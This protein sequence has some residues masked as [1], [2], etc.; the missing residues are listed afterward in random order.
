MELFVQLEVTEEM[1]MVSNYEKMKQQMQKEFLKYDQVSMTERFPIEANAEYLMFNFMGAPCRVYRKTGVVE[2]KSVHAK[3]FREAD[4]NEAMTVYDLLCYSKPD[5]APSRQF[6]N[7][8]SISKL[9]SAVSASSSGF[10]RREAL[11]FDHKNAALCDALEKLGG[12]IFGS[13][14]VAAQMSVFCGLEVL[15][16][17]WDSDEEF[18]PEIQ[19]LWDANVLSFMHYETIWFANSVLVRR[20]CE[21]M[22]QTVS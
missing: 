4:Y 10:F 7:M 9:H 13:G 5:A 22:E 2:C 8:Q 17:F 14:D 1:E 3:V 15:F 18:D 6:V 19:F 21:I 11:L 20:V 16:R 12:T